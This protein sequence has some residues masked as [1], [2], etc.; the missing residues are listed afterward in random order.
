MSE[1]LCIWD[2]RLRVMSF[3]ILLRYAHSTW[4]VE[5][6]RCFSETVQERSALSQTDSKQPRGSGVSKQSGRPTPIYDLSLD[7]EIGTLSRG[8]H[9]AAARPKWGRFRVAQARAAAQKH[10]IEIHFEHLPP[11]RQASGAIWR[12]VS[13]GL[14]A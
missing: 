1:L 7:F 12:F 4:Y 5:R 6:Q 14:L 8:R 11:L 2:G 3:F 9:A 13:A 10:M